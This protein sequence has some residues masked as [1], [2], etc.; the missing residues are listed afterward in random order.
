MFPCTDCP[1]CPIA[2]AAAEAGVSDDQQP[3]CGSLDRNQARP[4]QILFQEGNRATHLYVIRSGGVRQLR[5]DPGGGEHVVGLLGPGDTAGVEAL[6]G[7]CCAT[8]AEVIERSELCVAGRDEVALLLD[9]VPGLAVALVRST[10][11]R[12]E[13]ALG[14]QAC[15][16]VVGSASRIA[17]YLLHLSDP[18]DGDPTWVPQPLTQADLAAVV[19]V[20]A[21]TAC[22]VLARLRDGGLIDVRRNEIR[23]TDRR[24]LRRVVRC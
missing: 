21:E 3:P 22:R 6:V 18:G 13:R 16:G 8:T 11:R 23:I 15:L 24:G 17:A 12:L 10:H 20:S 5:R 2:A 4:G 19:G 7:G 1:G 9:A 14:Q